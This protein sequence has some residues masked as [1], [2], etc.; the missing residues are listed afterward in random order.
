MRLGVQ[1][2]VH[3]TKSLVTATEVTTLLIPK[4]IIYPYSQ[5]V[6]FSLH[7]H[8]ILLENPL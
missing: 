7:L 4:L 8:N 5:P 2:V 3:M 1:S 6:Q